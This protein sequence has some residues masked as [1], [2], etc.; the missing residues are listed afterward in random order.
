M[1]SCMFE[2]HAL[3]GADALF[4][5][6]ET[7]GAL[8]GDHSLVTISTAPSVT[9]RSNLG[10]GSEVLEI[11]ERPKSPVAKHE[12]HRNRLQCLSRTL[13]KSSKEG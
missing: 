8:I 4:G 13:L 12:R 9:T 1:G 5:I 2:E 10:T 7:D 11:C 6:S 3:I